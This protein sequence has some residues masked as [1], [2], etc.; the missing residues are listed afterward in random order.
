M[1]Q[2]K[3]GDNIPKTTPA[4]MPLDNDKLEK[5]L[6]ELA[7]R[8]KG[9]ARFYDMELIDKN[10]EKARIK[11]RKLEKERKE[12]A[13][14]LR[15]TWDMARLCKEIIS[16]NEGEWMELK[17]KNEMERKESEEKE[18]RLE[19][20]KLEK[21]KWKKKNN[22]RRIDNMIEKLNEKRKEEWKSIKDEEERKIRKE[23][24]EMQ[25]NLWKWR[26]SQKVL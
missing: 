8:N 1:K 17:E 5:E 22:Q 20:S 14:M 4:E 25:E 2:T 11:L 16:Q 23:K 10:R 12:K 18:L 21:E 9:D 24:Q 26:S 15:M 19:K 6:E 13:E 7:K 3:I